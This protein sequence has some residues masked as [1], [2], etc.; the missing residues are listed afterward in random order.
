[1]ITREFGSLLVPFS[2]AFDGVRIE[3]VQNHEDVVKAVLS[4]ANKD[5]YFYPPTIQTYEV[6]LK[7]GK[8]RRR[9]KN[10]ERPACVYHLPVTHTISVEKPVSTIINFEDAGLLVHLLA[11]VFGARLQ[12]SE[13]RIEGRVP[14]E[15][16]QNIHISTDTASHFL[17]ATYQ[18]WCNWPTEKRQRFVNIL[19]VYTRAKSLEWDW[20]EFMWQYTTFD[21]LYKLYSEL[22][23]KKASSHPKRFELICNELGLK[24]EQERIADICKARRLLVHE[25]MWGDTTIGHVYDDKRMHDCLA[26]FNARLICALVGYENT[27][28]RSTWTAM[29]SFLFDKA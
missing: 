12:F 28:M 22:S 23:G 1:M 26:R 27:F 18:R 6:S 15:S 24:Y 20:D 10:T 5:G 17:E 16:N 19:Y 11:F 29:G 2:T 14:T 7:T 21:A 9:I 4:I 13:W 3:P 25:A 8:P